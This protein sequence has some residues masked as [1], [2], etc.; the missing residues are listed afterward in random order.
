[1]RISDW[2]SDVCS[3]DLSREPVEVAIADEFAG[4]DVTLAA[5][6]MLFGEHRRLCNVADVDCRRADIECCAR[7]AGG[8]I[9]QHPAV[10]LRLVLLVAE[11]IGAPKRDAGHD[12]PQERKGGGWGKRGTVGE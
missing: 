3:S 10:R 2:S 1:M 12:A 11:G 4:N 5:A 8:A 9:A 7:L 6:A